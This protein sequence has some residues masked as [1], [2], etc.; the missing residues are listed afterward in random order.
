MAAEQLIKKSDNDGLETAWD[1]LAKQKIACGFGTAGVCCRICTMGPCRVSLKPGKG[2]ER[3]ICGA[4]ADV[5]VARNFARMIAAGSAAHSDHGRSICYDLLSAAETGD[6]RIADK[7][8]LIR[9]AER[10]DIEAKDKDIYD[11]AHEVAAQGLENFGSVTE[12]VTF[13]QSLPPQRLERWKQHG[14][15]PRAIDR[16]VISIMHSTHMGCMADAEALI[17]LS[18]K[19]AIA[20]G[21]L[22]S[23]MATEFS[24]IL[25]GTPQVRSTEANLG[26]LEENQVN[27]VLH[28]HEPSLS[29]MLVRAADLPEI[30]AL[31]ESV[32]AE[33]INLCGL[34]C[35]ANEMAMRHGVK[36]AGNFLHQELAVVTGAVEALI[37]DVQCILPSLAKL[38]ECFHTKFITTS[39]KA[40]ITGALHIELDERSRLESAK[41]ILNEAIKNYPHRNRDKVF[42]PDF[43]EKAYLGYSVEQIISILGGK[44]ETF[45]DKVD[46]MSPLVQVIANGSVK[47]I[48]AIVGCNNIR[49]TQDENHLEII[50]SLIEQ[51]ILVVTTGCAAQAA[52][53]HKFL[54]KNA[55]QLAGPGLQAVC[56]ALDIPPVLHMGS[57][58]DI[59]RILDLAGCV[60]LNL[61]VDIS[62]L[63]LAG[64]ASEYMSEKALTIGTYV[65]STGIDTWLGSMPPISGGPEV[66][67]IL[68]NRIKDWVG[69]SFYVE[70]N[71]HQLAKQVILR[72][73]EKRRELGLSHEEE[74]ALSERITRSMPEQQT[75]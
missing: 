54:Q 30:K 68:T 71:P 9:T 65:V 6:F 19:S 28:G 21:W 3:G 10:F 67:D 49:I 50:K 52:A 75:E 34:C 72:I 66:I 32:G 62:D 40:R 33:G 13:P 20:D 29:E 36:I 26:V 41:E 55:A 53:K 56:E 27:I 60:A 23:S 42:I 12:T 43:K 15:V 70:E 35:T 58:V 14:L 31:A 2:A 69:A 61:G 46:T 16:E 17:K 45:Q 25:F 59:S 7:E 1:R 48:A 22:G 8:K 37:V 5:I 39:P 47:G 51:D 24:D 38:S 11:L 63:P 57:C 18:L 4:T 44:H 74:K 64:I 73:N